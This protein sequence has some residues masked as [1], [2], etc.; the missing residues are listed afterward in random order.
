[1]P[2]T[3]IT[4]DQVKAFMQ[5]IADISNEATPEDVSP[6]NKWIVESGLH[7]AAKRHVA[8]IHTFS[9]ANT[10]SSTAPPIATLPNEP[11]E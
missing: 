9:P 1:M 3:R 2:H 6:E 10:T 4:I 7:I 5:T 11:N 8:N